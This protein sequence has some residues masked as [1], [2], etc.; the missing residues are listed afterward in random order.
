LI[1]AA[2]P[3][4]IRTTRSAPRA[5]TWLHLR[6]DPG[7]TGKKGV[8]GNDANDDLVVTKITITGSSA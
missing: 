2:I 5:M 4:T 7:E 3:L 6:P 8:V 1:V